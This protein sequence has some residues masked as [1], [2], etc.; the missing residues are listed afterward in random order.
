[1]LIRLFV[2]RV[3]KLQ[4]GSRVLSRA[5]EGSGIIDFEDENGALTTLLIEFVSAVSTVQSI[6]GCD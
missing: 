1:M 4:R 3:A 5:M 2:W 6:P